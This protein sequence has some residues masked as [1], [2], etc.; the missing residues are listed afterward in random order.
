MCRNLIPALFLPVLAHAQALPDMAE[1]DRRFAEV[2][3]VHETAAHDLVIEWD[4]KAGACD[5]VI[6]SLF[7][8]LK[9]PC[10]AVR[11]ALRRRTLLVYQAACYQDFME[12]FE[13]NREAVQ[14]RLEFTEQGAAMTAALASF[15]NDLVRICSFRDYQETH[16]AFMD[17][18]ARSRT[19]KPV[20]WDSFGSMDS[21]A[22][23]NYN[24]DPAVYANGAVPPPA[25]LPV[26]GN[27][28]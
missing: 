24:E 21:T 1:L 22:W 2:V 20:D 17:M 27:R 5:A 10:R 14:A 11:A 8:N 18:L 25:G 19:A 23:W 15:E 12:T 26:I 7:G 28:P 6:D 13:A 9:A 4:D 16:L 3:A